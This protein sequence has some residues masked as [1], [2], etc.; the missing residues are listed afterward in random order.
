ML[1]NLESVLDD[2][3]EILPKQKEQDISVVRSSS[4]KML[5]DKNDRGSPAPPPPP[6]AN[7]SQALQPNNRISHS[8]FFCRDCKRKIDYINSKSYEISLKQGWEM[9]EKVG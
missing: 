1:L 4:S 6:S 5:R 2:I 9:V 8:K 7:L 3:Y